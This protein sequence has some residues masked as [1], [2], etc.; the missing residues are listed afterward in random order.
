MSLEQLPMAFDDPGGLGASTQIREG[1]RE[2]HLSHQVETRL[3]FR[4]QKLRSSPMKPDRSLTVASVL[5]STA[6]FENGTR[7][8][9]IVADREAEALCSLEQVLRDSALAQVEA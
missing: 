2:I 7:G 4:V 6:S 1:M 3:C 9:E 8:A 5:P